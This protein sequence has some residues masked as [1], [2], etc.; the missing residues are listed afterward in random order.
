MGHPA[1]SPQQFTLLVIVEPEPHLL[2]VQETSIRSLA[3]DQRVE[4]RI[5]TL[6]II[7][8]LVSLAGPAKRRH[9]TA[10]KQSQSVHLFVF[11]TS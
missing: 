1:H 7:A 5:I 4:I 9:P 11:N 8:T 6:Q 2:F 3:D 10:Q